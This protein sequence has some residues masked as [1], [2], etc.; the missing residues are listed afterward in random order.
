ME[1]VAVP[2]VGGG[3]A[4]RNF[5]LNDVDVP[6]VDERIQYAAAP[7]NEGDGCE[8]LALILRPAVGV[9]EPPV[10]TIL[11]EEGVLAEFVFGGEL[12]GC[13]I[14]TGG[15]EGAE[16]DRAEKCL[17]DAAGVLDG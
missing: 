1:V 2:T 6:P 17:V 13:L 11:A 14:C 3:F 9:A 7:M 15:K 5:V 16:W 12:P 4:S 8:P 10:F